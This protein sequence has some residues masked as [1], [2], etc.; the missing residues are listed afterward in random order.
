MRYQTHENDFQVKIFLNIWFLCLGLSLP[1]VKAGGNDFIKSCRVTKL[2]AAL[3][4]NKECFS[5]ETFYFGLFYGIS[6][7]IV[8]FQNLLMQ[9]IDSEA[10][11][12]IHPNRGSDDGVVLGKLGWILCHL[13]RLSGRNLGRIFCETE[14][15]KL[16]CPQSQSVI[17]PLGLLS[18]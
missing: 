10:E 4:F 1:A 7:E 12:L 14:L 6:G 11:D 15:I 2:W 3:C 9:H 5:R 13:S 8:S 18:I 16:K 17:A